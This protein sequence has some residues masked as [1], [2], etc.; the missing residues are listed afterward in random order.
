MLA[1][2]TANEAA[3]KWNISH[4]RVLALCKENR[5]ANI[6]MLGNM[7]IIPIDAQKPEDARSRG[8]SESKGKSVKPFL[9][10]AGGKGQLLKEIERYYPFMDGRITKY[11]EPFVGGGAVLFDILSKYDLEEIYISDIS[12]ELM[13]TYR[14]IRDDIDALIE[15]LYTLQNAYIP[16]DTE[17]RKAYYM[18]KR[19]RFNDLTIGENKTTNIE[20]AALM[21]FLNKTCFN[22]LYRVN[23]K[24]KF[25]VPMGAYKNPMVCD[26]SNLRAVSEKLQRVTIVCGD[27]KE[28]ADFIDENTFVYFDPPYRPLTDTASFTA[29]TEDLFN[30]QKQIEL[31]EFVDAMHK[32]GAKVVV[33]NSDPKN[34][35]PEDDFFDDIYA[36]HK[37][38]RIEATRM[39]N[40]NSEARGKIKELL[41]SNF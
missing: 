34:A 10:W 23:R 13:N 7:W 37:I 25:N 2:M 29:Y 22:G 14:I 16:L 1:Y 27:Y 3:A 8:Y 33:S 11:A 18:Q 19:D 35:N 41:I 6:A 31:A 24:G 20:K 36:T 4:R 12:A 32:K 38:K 28:A 26:E 9:K 21:I 40:S 30:D 15:M 39:I 5:I 17:K